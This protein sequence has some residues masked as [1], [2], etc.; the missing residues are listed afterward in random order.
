M[1]ARSVPFAYVALVVAGLVSASPAFAQL[2]PYTPTGSRV[3]RGPEAVDPKLARRMQ[4]DIGRCVYSRHPEL[5]DRFLQSSDLNGADFHRLGVP[6]ED[7]RDDFSMG[8]CLGWAMTASQ[9]EASLS[10][11][12]SGLRTLLAEEAYLD[13]HDGPLILPEGSEEFLSSR[14]FSAPLESE[15]SRMV[16]MFADCVIFNAAA[17]ADKV[18]RTAPA[19]DEESAAVRALVPALSGCLME[20]QELELTAASVRAIVAD[21]LWSR[22]HY[23]ASA[24]SMFAGSQTA[25]DK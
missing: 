17:E 6:A 25:P 19:S 5:A 7:L 16:S 4:K 11:R 10:I 18:L 3:A 8:D 13:R 2:E 1:I 15:D 24:N 23:G 22:S 12:F 21:G 20:G 9:S 14:F